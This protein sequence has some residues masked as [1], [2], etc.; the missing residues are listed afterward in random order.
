MKCSL[1][2]NLCLCSTFV[3]K[4]FPCAGAAIQFSLCGVE[5]EPEVFR[6]SKYLE[7]VVLVGIWIIDAAAFAGFAVVR[8]A[9][10]RVVFRPK[11]RQCECE[12]GPNPD[13]LDVHYRKVVFLLGNFSVN[14]YQRQGWYRVGIAFQSRRKIS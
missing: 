11:V 7:V 3:N 4:G 1:I 2:G 5:I 9:R 14:P 12:P 13:V 6:I 8:P 10:V